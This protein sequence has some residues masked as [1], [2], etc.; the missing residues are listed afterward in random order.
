MP[1]YEYRCEACG[2]QEEV[3]QKVADSPLTTCSK[4]GKNAL[5]KVISQ[6]QFQ[7]KGTGW[8]V[9]DFKNSGAKKEIKKESGEG[10]GGKTDT[11]PPKES[12]E[13][14]SK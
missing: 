8:Y 2:N 13:P 6:T 10:E 4:C 9:T 3:L 12:K 5:T 11:T 14:E 7:L 1:I